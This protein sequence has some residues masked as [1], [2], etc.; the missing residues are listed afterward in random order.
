MLD[1][2]YIHNERRIY[3]NESCHTVFLSCPW[4]SL[5]LPSAV[6]PEPTLG[7]GQCLA[8]GQ[9]IPEEHQVNTPDRPG[10]IQRLDAERRSKTVGLKLISSLLVTVELRDCTLQNNS[11]TKPHSH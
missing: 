4:C 8:R 5:D 2:L 7:I 3:T 9:L 10:K 11:R 1:V 6:N